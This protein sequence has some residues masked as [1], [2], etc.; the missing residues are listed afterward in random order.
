MLFWT[1]DA[2]SF[3]L[4]AVIFGIGYGG[5]AGGFPIL[6]RRYYGLAPVG[7]AYGV[8]MLGASMGMA[9]GGWLGGPIFDLTGSYDI[10][11]WLSV[12][13]SVAGAVSILALESTRTLLI[14]DWNAERVAAAQPDG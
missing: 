10:V 11:L 2:W 4:F 3:Y 9:L 1:H 5:E 6:N 8:Q 13:A 12:V 14:P 7:S